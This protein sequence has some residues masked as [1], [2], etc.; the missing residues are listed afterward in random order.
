MSA[1]P[2][3][4][5][6]KV[7]RIYVFHDG[8]N[9][10]VPATANIA[11]LRDSIITETCKAVSGSL[12]S[13]EPFLRW[14]MFLPANAAP[15]V[16]KQLDTNGISVVAS[17][18]K[19]SS[20]DFKLKEAVADFRDEHRDAGPAFHEQ[21][22]VLLAS[23][24]SDFAPEVRQLKR[25]GYIVVVVSLPVVRAAYIEQAHFVLSW[26]HMLKSATAA[27]TAP[28][29]SKSSGIA[30]RGDGAGHLARG[31]GRD[32]SGTSFPAVKAGAAETLATPKS[33]LAV[34]SASPEVLV[35]RWANA[36]VGAFRKSS[37]TGDMVTMAS[38]G[39]LAASLRPEGCSAKLEKTLRGD[40]RW[41]IVGEGPSALVGLRESC[42]GAGGSGSGS[43]GGVPSTGRGSACGG[44]AS[45]DFEAGILARQKFA[46]PP[47]PGDQ[48]ID[49]FLRM[50][51]GAWQKLAFLTIPL[52]I[53]MSTEALEALWRSFSADG[54]Y[55]LDKKD[56]IWNSVVKLNEHVREALRRARGLDEP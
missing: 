27:R 34:S 30:G 21:T 23:G 22:A 13:R 5:A 2:A 10:A 41:V 42:G 44:D 28:P 35:R 11:A 18:P 38:L 15:D 47:L 16:K 49:Y 8:E 52:G 9:L 12:P 54:R 50:P 40:S 37:D 17:G 14:Q 25:E 6:A 48:L 45:A 53:N 24:D 19:A 32:L 55:E 20:V 1:A 33:S 3:A 31:G 51:A 26:A 43:R 46:P 4:R 7:A 56:H 36:I 29:P 39:V